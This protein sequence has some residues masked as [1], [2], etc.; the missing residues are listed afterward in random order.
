MTVGLPTLPLKLLGQRAP[1]LLDA[2]MFEAWYRLEHAVITKALHHKQALGLPPH[3]ER[4]LLQNLEAMPKLGY[5]A[6]IRLRGRRERPVCPCLPT[7]ATC[8]VPHHVSMQVVASLARATQHPMKPLVD[9]WEA[10]GA[11][12]DLLEGATLFDNYGRA[13]SRLGYAPRSQALVPVD[14][15]IPPFWTLRKSSYR[16]D[17]L[18][19]L[20]ANALERT[21]IGLHV[22]KPARF[23]VTFNPFSVT[24]LSLGSLPYSTDSFIITIRAIH[25]HDCSPYR[26]S[27][28]QRCL[29]A[30][31]FAPSK[32]GTYCPWRFRSTN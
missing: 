23:C 17:I 12:H 3:R 14:Y 32:A 22:H 11:A 7:M 25:C 9:A 30:V 20:L 10:S 4:R 13:V 8:L 2:L 29:V 19:R 26:T 28:L 16:A 1:T 5:V 18:T 27:R 21:V 24:H 15:A 31:E 6:E